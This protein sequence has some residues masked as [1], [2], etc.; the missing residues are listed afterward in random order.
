MA[1]TMGEVMH[2]VCPSANTGSDAKYS[3]VIA[4][5]ICVAA[6][7]TSNLGLNF[8][9][10][11]HER[12]KRKPLEK[13]KYRSIWMLGFVGIVAGAIGDF[14]ALGFG[15]QSIV[16]PLGSTT[17]VANVFFAPMMLG[18][19]ISRSDLIATMAIVAGCVVSVAFASHKDC[20]LT[21]DQLFDLYTTERF[22]YYASLIVSTVMLF[23]VAIRHMEIVELENPYLY[24]KKYMKLHRFSYASLS[25]IVG[26]Q[27]VLFAKTT[28]E[29]FMDWLDSGRFFLG[30]FPTYLVLLA[31]GMSVTLQI[32]WLNCGLA[33]WDALYNVPVFQ[34]F[35]ILV[36]VM[37]G[38][39]FY[40]EFAGFTTEQTILFPLG[41]LIA[42]CGVVWLSQR[43]A[44]E[45]KRRESIDVT[46]DGHLVRT[47]ARS[48]GGI[49]ESEEEDDDIDSGAVD[50]LSSVDRHT[51]DGG[52]VEGV[53]S[54]RG[55]RFG[56][57]EV[58]SP[59]G[60]PP[61]TEAPGSIR[62]RTRRGYSETRGRDH[63]K[64]H[65]RLAF[66]SM[67]PLS[68]AFHSGSMYT[69][70]AYSRDEEETDHPMLSAADAVLSVP[71]RIARRSSL[72][73]SLSGLFRGA[74]SGSSGSN[75]P[76]VST[77]DSEDRDRAN[78]ATAFAAAA[79]S[80]G[81]AGAGTG[82]VAGGTFD[83]ADLGRDRS[84]TFS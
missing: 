83:R 29:L 11:A 19:E 56:S 41:V 40:G 37:G 74:R 10:M 73:D 45:V 17:L 6:N 28:V 65:N 72:P 81:G 42:V 61:P 13:V 36:S 43:D 32:Y 80:E 77:P 23:L 14:A 79:R 34:S 16:A 31:M 9:K 2:T 57:L 64:A 71:R 49:D 21:V 3:W 24:R 25:G 27:S 67:D 46:G 70:G 26:A 51:D 35:W 8:Q 62:R 54:P 68:M 44:D 55:G 12:R 69:P 39:V 33:R 76:S 38:G 7:T 30:Y 52:D 15:A 63:H 58:T 66:L 20:L 22:A 53:R 60:V 50:L 75:L 59:I 47:T 1:A 82:A 4:V 78:S 84:T 18:E 48:F 5:V